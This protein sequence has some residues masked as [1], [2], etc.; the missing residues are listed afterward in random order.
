MFYE[1]VFPACHCD[2]ELVEGLRVTLES[3]DSTDELE[4]LVSSE[5]A[6]DESSQA[7]RAKNAVNKK[8]VRDC[9]P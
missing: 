2:P 3:G 5:L 1:E 7:V 6:D 8:M 9:F 4:T